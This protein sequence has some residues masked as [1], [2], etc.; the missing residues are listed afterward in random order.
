MKKYKRCLLLIKISLHTAKHYI[1]HLELEL[2]VLHRFNICKISISLCP[3]EKRMY[4]LH[5]PYCQRTILR[6][7]HHLSRRLTALDFHQLNLFALP[8]FSIWIRF[9]IG[10]LSARNGSRQIVQ[11]IDGD[12]GSQSNASSSPRT[13]FKEEKQM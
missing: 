13:V 3:M 10:A 6:S 11:P 12:V 2:Y 9:T 8:I 7:S 1:I 5:T 4:R